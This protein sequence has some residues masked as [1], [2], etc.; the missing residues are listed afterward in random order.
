[1]F[2]GVCVWGDVS[3]GCAHIPLDPEAHPPG[4]TPVRTEQPVSQN[5]RLCATKKGDGTREDV[6]PVMKACAS[7]IDYLIS[8]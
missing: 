8:L 3:R 5:N 1:M 2:R 4:G 7:K 6:F